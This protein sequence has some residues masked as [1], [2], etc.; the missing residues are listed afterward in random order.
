MVVETILFDT[1]GDG[2][3]G[4]TFIDILDSTLHGKFPSL[5]GDLCTAW[6]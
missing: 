2:E 3:P 5:S 4:G 1:L 6:D